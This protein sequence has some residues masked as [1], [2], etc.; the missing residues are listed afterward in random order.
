[1]G[2]SDRDY[3]RERDRARRDS[4]RPFTPPSTSAGWPWTLLIWLVAGFVLFKLYV[5][6]EPSQHQAP[7][8]T[9]RIQQQELQAGTASRAEVDEERASAEV[10]RQPPPTTTRNATPSS[11][12]IYLCRAYNGGT[13]W[14]QAH[15][16]Q[17]NA[18]IERIAYVPPD[19]PFDQKVAIATEQRRHSAAMIQ[20]DIRIAQTSEGRSASPHNECKAL[21]ARIVQFDALARQPQSAQMQDWIASQRKEAR[22]RQFR[23]RC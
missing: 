15:C 3:M 17:H 7:A 6:H 23:L 11:N 22:D 18:L 21:D 5:K 13:F 8:K 12:T 16:N 4:D 14:A 1:M 19:L 2:L 10:A 20:N 9:V